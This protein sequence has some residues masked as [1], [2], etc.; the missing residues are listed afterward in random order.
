MRATVIADASF[1]Q[2]NRNTPP[3]AGW[4]AWVRVD[5]I[6]RPLRGYGIIRAP[7]LRTSTDAELY[8]AL[9]GIWMAARCGATNILLRSDC[10]SVV[11]LFNTSPAPSKPPSRLRQLMREGLRHPDIQGV[12]VTG[13]HVKG[14]G[15]INSRATWVNDWCDTHA[16]KAMR[17]SRKGQACQMIL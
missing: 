5:T 3:H 14:H 11:E 12:R 15:V 10:L 4:A 9:N 16:K 2:Q 13:Y 17:R 6:Q 8:A 7:E 1:W